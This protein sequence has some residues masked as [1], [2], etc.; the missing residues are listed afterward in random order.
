[1]RTGVL[2]T[3]FLSVFF[4]GSTVSNVDAQTAGPADQAAAG[5]AID[6]ANPPEGFVRPQLDASSASKGFSYPQ[7][8]F[9]EASEGLVTLKLLVH[10]DGTVGDVQ[11]A[12]SS[13]EMELDDKAVEL[14]KGRH[15][16]PAT[17]HGE[18]VAAWVNVNFDFKLSVSERV[19]TPTSYTTLVVPRDA[20]AYKYVKTKDYPPESERLGEQGTVRLR[21]QV[22]E[23]GTYGD[24][25]ILKS[26]GFPR[27]D[28][29]AITIARAR[30][31]GSGSVPEKNAIPLGPASRLGPGRG[32][33]APKEINGRVL[34]PRRREDITFKLK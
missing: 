12:K 17:L 34:H 30:H 28:D 21:F 26:S 7:I 32:L 33:S 22:L 5:Q 15:Y 18:P 4:A 29:A 1:M 11:F 6:A 25:E 16:R 9:I 8:A 24:A 13:G 10:V 27:L 2:A 20:N 14:A 19:I 3:I 23:D 31:V